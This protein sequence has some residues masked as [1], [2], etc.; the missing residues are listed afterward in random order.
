MVAALARLFQARLVTLIR[1]KSSLTK[2]LSGVDLR[3][4]MQTVYLLYLGGRARRQDLEGG[5]IARSWLL[6]A[7]RLDITERW[8]YNSTEF[9]IIMPNG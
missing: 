8:G 2:Q 6:A 7:G 1:R 5:Q 9:Q 3:C 4:S